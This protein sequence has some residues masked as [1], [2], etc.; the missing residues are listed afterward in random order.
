MVMQVLPSPFPALGGGPNGP[1]AKKKGFR[2]EWPAV[3]L[4]IMGLDGVSAQVAQ[5]KA[6]APGKKAGDTLALLLSFG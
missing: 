5:L 4:Q 1:I 3:G 6:N 2:V